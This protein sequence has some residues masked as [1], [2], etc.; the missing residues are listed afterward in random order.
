MTTDP[1][2]SP[3]HEGYLPAIRLINTVNQLCSFE[4]GSIPLG[5][6]LDATHFFT[7]TDVSYE[8]LT[9]PAPRRQYVITLKG[10][11]KFRVSNGD[12]FILEPGVILI[13]ADTLGEG[14]SWELIGNP[15][16]IRVYIPLADASDDYFIAD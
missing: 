3:I 8:H 11:L 16:W 14:H 6:H 15:E 2:T 4:T 10:K 12:T 7:K 9:H 5:K 1:A 13:A